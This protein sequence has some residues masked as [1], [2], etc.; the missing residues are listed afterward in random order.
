[1]RAV[2]VERRQA[3]VARLL[4][5]RASGRLHGEAICAAAESLGAGERSVWR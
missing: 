2:V 3:V 1:M 5:L 4:V